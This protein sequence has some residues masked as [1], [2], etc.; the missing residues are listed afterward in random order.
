M[1]DLVEAV[2]ERR[3]LKAEVYFLD[4]LVWFLPVTLNE[5]SQSQKCFQTQGDWPKASTI[6]YFIY[7][8]VT[9]VRSYKSYTITHLF[10]C[11]FLLSFPSLSFLYIFTFVRFQNWLGAKLFFFFSFYLE[12]LF[13]RPCLQ[14]FLGCCHNS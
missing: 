7:S 4:V 10:N 1:V 6:Y 8:M 3:I 2:T 5:S 13:R 14:L 12:P 11:M 9:V